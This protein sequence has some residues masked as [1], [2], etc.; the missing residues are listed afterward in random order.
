MV[1]CIEV[2]EQLQTC[3]GVNCLTTWTYVLLLFSAHCGSE[4]GTA[5]TSAPWAVAQ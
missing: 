3:E 1:F 2:A 4:Q 5:R